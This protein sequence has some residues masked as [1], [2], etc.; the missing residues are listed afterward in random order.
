VQCMRGVRCDSTTVVLHYDT[1]ITRTSNN[2]NNP[3]L[4]VVGKIDEDLL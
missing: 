1:F 4:T 2:T 3:T